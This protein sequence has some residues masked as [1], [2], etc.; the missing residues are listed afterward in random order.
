MISE[1]AARIDPAKAQ[2]ACANILVSL[3]GYAEW[4]SDHLEWIADALRPVHEGTG[5][6][7]Y[8]DQD[9]AAVEFWEQYL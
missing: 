4:S 9:D 5:L 7:S 1:I 8:T 6:P 3:G 2:I